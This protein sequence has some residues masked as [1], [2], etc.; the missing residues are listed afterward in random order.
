MAFESNYKTAIVRRTASAPIKRLINYGAF[1]RFLV[2]GTKILD[3]GCGKGHDVDKVKDYY[4]SYVFSN[5]GLKIDGIVM[6]K[7]D[8]YYFPIKL[9]KGSYNLIL[10]TYVLNIVSKE[11]QEKI[12]TNIIE[13]LVPNG[14]AY[15]S[16]RRDI[17]TEGT[18]TQRWVELLYPF[19]KWA[20]NSKY[21][22]YNI[23]K[24][25]YIAHITYLKDS[26]D[27]ERISSK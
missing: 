20:I 18:S 26:K 5:S 16:V 8:P 14:V 15:F 11:D 1:Y 10:C 9:E 17:P 19:R 6:D 24:E 27:G 4:S 7:F 25:E 12:I 21:A 3:Y 2:P 23:R 13:L 22:I